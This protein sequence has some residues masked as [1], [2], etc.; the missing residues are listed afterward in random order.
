[1]LSIDF[2]RSTFAYNFESVESSLQIV[3]LIFISDSFDQ[4]KLF[5]ELPG[6]GTFFLGNCCSGAN[7]E[8]DEGN[9][10][11][12]GGPSDSDGIGGGGGGNGGGIG[13]GGGGGGKSDGIGEVSNVSS[14]PTAQGSSIF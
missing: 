10:G 3:P 6:F 13:G 1:M 9:V 8:E 14:F 12:I 5:K 4:L 2:N 7:S 11:G